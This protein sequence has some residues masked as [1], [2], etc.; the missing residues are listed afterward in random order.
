M[1]IFAIFCLFGDGHSN[2]CET[3]SRYG[4]NLHFCNDCGDAGLAAQ[5]RPP[6]LRPHGLQPARLLCPRDFPARKLELV[7]I[8]SS[9]GSSPPRGWTGVS[10]AGRRILYHWATREAPFI[11]IHMC[12]FSR[13]VYSINGQLNI[14]LG[15]P[16]GSDGKESACIAGDLSSIPG[17]GFLADRMMNLDMLVWMASPSITSLASHLLKDFD[18]EF[19]SSVTKIYLLDLHKVGLIFK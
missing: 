14:K 13:I 8:C 17:L 19:N 16:G 6:L 18:A 15:F 5:S 11:Y 7:A 2:S 4:F 12:I 3:I 10:C 9:R 1:Q